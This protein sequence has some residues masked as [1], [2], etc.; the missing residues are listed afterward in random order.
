MKTNPLLMKTRRALSASFPALAAERG[1]LIVSRAKQSGATTNGKDILKS[2]K[3]PIDKQQE[4]HALRAANAHLA[5]ICMLVNATLAVSAAAPNPNFDKHAAEQKFHALRWMDENGEIPPDGLWRAL[6]H[7]RQALADSGLSPALHDRSVRKQGPGPQ[8]PKNAG[9]QTNSW[10]WLGPGN[11]GG[12]VRS[13]VIHP[14]MTNI[15]WCGSVS[16]GIWKSTNSGASWFP[17]DDFMANLAV[18]CMVMDPANPDVIFVG[19]GEGFFNGDSIRGAGI[20]KTADGGTTWTRLA[21]TTNSLFQYVNRLAIDPNS[22]QVILAATHSGVFRSTD[23]GGSWT[24]PYVTETLDVA[25]HP[26]DSSQCIA[27][28]YNGRALYST[29]GGMNWISATGLPAPSGILAGRVE[30]AYSRSNP[31]TVF[32]SVD[33]NQGE[34]YGSTDGGHSYL[35]RN[36]GTNYLDGS[37]WYCNA[38]WADPTDANIL[39]V[40]G[41]NLWRSTNGGATLTRIS[42]GFL[43]P[44]SP[45]EDQHVIVSS[46]GFDGTSVKSVYFGNDGGIYRVADVYTVSEASGWEDLNHNLGMAQFYGGAGN[47]DTGVIIGGTQDNG[48]LRYTP[49]EG[50][51]NWTRMFSGDGG[52]CAAD[53][54]DP[55]YFYGEHIRLQIHRSFNGGLFSDF[56]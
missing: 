28:R 38:I 11:L 32:A 56:L 19:T 30:L 13:I 41:L 39:I 47:P 21:S 22:S 23:G 9:I 16:G 5:L 45:H 18:A 12:R 31:S 43:K 40:G 27:A 17:L 34:V 6:E 24:R 46:P 49:R 3:N 42:Q 29:N 7:R 36:R 51:G 25:F 55:N 53:P 44:M 8:S 50:A 14:T 35:R 1:L 20:F 37:G 48:T 4:S 54:T 15:L 52:F 10:T 26:T 2:M 33:N